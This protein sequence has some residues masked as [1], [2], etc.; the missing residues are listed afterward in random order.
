MRTKERAAMESLAV[1]PDLVWPDRDP[2]GLLIADD[3]AGARSLLAG[4]TRETVERVAV[5]EAT[6]G[7]E[8]I[9]V[10]LQQRPRIA[11]L[12]CELPLLG[13]IGVALVLRELLPGLRVALQT[14]DP[15][16]H[17]DRARE[18]C[19]PLFDKVELGHALRW[20]DRQAARGR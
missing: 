10:A 14:A 6:D 3:D 8:A 12:D 9:R 13:G 4:R 7:A 5:S 19:L 2:V 15:A 17:S 16:A 11:L 20:L 1:L 18:L